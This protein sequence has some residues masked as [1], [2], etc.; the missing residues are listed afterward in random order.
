M[1]IANRLCTTPNTIRQITETKRKR[2]V[3]NAALEFAESDSPYYSSF[4]ERV[5]R[6]TVVKHATTN[7]ARVA[8]KHGETVYRTVGY[9]CRRRREKPNGV[10]SLLRRVVCY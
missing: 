7:L 5:V 10:I 6:R 8:I 9:A 4:R 1:R 2:N 3:S